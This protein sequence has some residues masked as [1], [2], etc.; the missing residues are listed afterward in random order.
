[1]RKKSRDKYFFFPTQIED[2]GL[3]LNSAELKLVLG[4]EHVGNR[5]IQ[6]D[7]LNVDKYRDVA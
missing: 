7:G 3:S 1:M 2:G 5:G 4:S 6:C